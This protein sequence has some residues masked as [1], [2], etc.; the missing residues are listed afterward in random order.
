MRDKSMATKRRTFLKAAGLCA[1]SYACLLE[2][3]GAKPR[4]A[5]GIAVTIGLNEVDAKHYGER[6]LL[7]GCVNDANEIKEIAADQ[8]FACNDPLLD[9]EATRSAV[10]TAI[11]NAANRLKNGDIFLLQYSGHGGWLK[12]DSG[13]EHDGRDETWCLFDGMLLDDELAKLWATFAP[14]VRVLVLSDSCHSGTVTRGDAYR[15]AAEAGD[16]PATDRGNLATD[17][18]SAFRFLP[19]E[20]VRTTFD[21]NT[22]FY[23]A[24]SAKVKRGGRP[25]IGASILLMSGCQDNQLAADLG[26]HGLFTK[27]LIEVWNKGKYGGNYREFHTAIVREMPSTQSPNFY[28][29]GKPDTTF[30]NQKPFTV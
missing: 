8:G 12:D 6:M 19:D 1:A 20:V 22:Q 16:L 9:A 15:A 28:P 17:Q 3:N 14:G 11:K 30:W 29:N 24:L 25:K 7:R 23:K 10:I 27:R 21:R 26:D 4:K 13:D 2:A 18:T 5:K